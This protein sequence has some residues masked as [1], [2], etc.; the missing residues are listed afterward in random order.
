MFSRALIACVL[1][2]VLAGCGAGPSSSPP[3]AGTVSGHVQL[4]ACGG[5]YPAAGETGC[6]TDPYPDATLTFAL[7][8]LA[9]TGSVETVTTDSS[10]FYRVDLK[11]GTYT[12]RAT[13][14]GKP[15]SGSQQVI[16]TAGT[17]VTADLVYTIQL[18]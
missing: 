12:V 10:G 16:V 1:A 5:A 4:R 18:P 17:T 13:G 8:Q 15:A 11:A 3:S 6:T 2:A 9:G 14:G 7:N